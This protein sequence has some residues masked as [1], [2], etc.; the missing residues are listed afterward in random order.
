MQIKLLLINFSLKKIIV[1]LNNF[2]YFWEG[3]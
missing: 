1:K 3:R 2:V